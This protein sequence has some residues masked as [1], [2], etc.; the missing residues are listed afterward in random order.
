MDLDLER[1]QL[2]SLLINSCTDISWD[3]FI[4]FF[5]DEGLDIPIDAC[6]DLMLNLQGSVCEPAI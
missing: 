2:C 1:E 3:V 5:L 6:I 4:K